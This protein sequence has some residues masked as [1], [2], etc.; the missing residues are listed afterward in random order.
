[1]RFKSR[2]SRT[3]RSLRGSA[4]QS[5]HL[6]GCANAR[7]LKVTYVVSNFPSSYDVLIDSYLSVWCLLSIL[8]HSLLLQ[9]QVL[10]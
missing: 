9:S 6:G 5:F 10:A 8:L 3:V 2:I 1:M 4:Q 7:L